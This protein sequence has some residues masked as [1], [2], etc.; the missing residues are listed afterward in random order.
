MKAILI[1]FDKLNRHMLPP[2]GSEWIHA[3]NFER[4]ASHTVTFENAY[5][6]STP[7]MPT[8]RELHTG[9]HNV[10]HCICGPLEPFDD[11]MPEILK[12]NSVYSDHYP[13]NRIAYTRSGYL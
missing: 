1:L 3:P 7:C 4:L 9:R 5:V 10:L 11:S 2:Y 6:G 13:G 12:Q 8:R